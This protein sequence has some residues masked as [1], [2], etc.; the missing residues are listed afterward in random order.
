MPVPFPLA[1]IPFVTD[2]SIAVRAVGDY[3]DLCPE[4]QKLAVGTDGLFAPGSPWVLTSASTNFVTCGV[5]PNN[6]IALTGPKPFYTSTG[7]LFAVESVSGN[8]ATLRRINQPAGSGLPP[9][10]ASGL[11]G[12]AFKCKTFG[13][14]IDAAAFDIKQRFGVD[15]NQSYRGSSWIYNPRV[16]E[17]PIILTVL[18][19]TY[20]ASN[21]SN[22]GDWAMKLALYRTELEEVLDRVS[23]RWG[24]LGNSG[25]P[26]TRMSCRITR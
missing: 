17:Q 18:V 24:P 7:E 11:N 10:P 15:D 21:R 20:G 26:V 2:E 9:A 8:T 1:V 4:W 25:S 22:D 19:R 13:P 3:I 16:F 6:I 14:Q 5:G 12:V 23:V